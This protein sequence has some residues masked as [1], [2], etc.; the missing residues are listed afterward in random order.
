MHMLSARTGRVRPFV[1]TRTYDD[2]SA[3]TF[4]I[5][6]TT[7]SGSGAD[8]T[9][10]TSYVEVGGR[11]DHICDALDK[12]QG[13]TVTPRLVANADDTEQS[14]VGSAERNQAIAD[15]VT[16]SVDVTPVS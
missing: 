10:Q 7:Y 5:G 2:G 13:R 8:Q 4:Q 6:L 3:A 11:S 1:G 12:S 16:E 15:S 14:Y 9:Y